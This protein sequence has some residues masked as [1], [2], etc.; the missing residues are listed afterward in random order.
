VWLVERISNWLSEVEAGY[1]ILQLRP[2][3]R[4]T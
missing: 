2:R 3:N 4:L 1:Q